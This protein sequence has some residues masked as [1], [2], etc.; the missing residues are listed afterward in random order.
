MCAIRKILYMLRVKHLIFCHIVDCNYN[1]SDLMKSWRH[2]N[3]KFSILQ[4]II[5]IYYIYFDCFNVIM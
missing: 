1:Y 3:V 2:W 4:C 5:Y